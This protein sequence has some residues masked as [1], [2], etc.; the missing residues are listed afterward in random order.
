MSSNRKKII[1]NSFLNKCKNTAVTILLASFIFYG[2]QSHCAS[3]LKF[4]I[5]SDS[6]FAS[7]KTDTS[8]K[9]LKNS[10][11][12]L[13]D[14]ITQINQETNIDF[15][16][17][18]G[19]LI[20]EAYE[21]ELKAFLPYANK[22]NS[23]WYFTFGNHDTMLGGYLDEKLFIKMVKNSNEN[24]TFDKPY[25]S[26]TPKNGYRVIALDTIIRDRLTTL[27]QID[28]AQ[29]RWLDNELKKYPDDIILIFMHI[30]IIEPYAS[31]S[32]R[33]I[34]ANEVDTLLSKYK[35]PI[36][37]FQGHYHGTKISQKNNIIYISTPSLVTYPNAFRT[38]TIN[39][40]DEKV[41]FDIKLKE[42]NLKNLQNKA[43]LMIFVSSI[44]SGLEN[45]RNSIIT[46]NKENKN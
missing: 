34:N 9:L 36:A 14:A 46:I 31:E 16:M 42:T 40:Y 11:E 5:I 15:T 37:V 27:G 29:M 22:L 18:T 13:D 35:N 24:F 21:Y 4:A 1:K 12:L 19:D 32:H 6:H 41:E 33:L 8:Y 43:K 28:E 17:F 44:Y 23:K 25:Y 30:P 20:D 2:L 3:S 45:D 39:N 26:F 38:V 10:S 7:S